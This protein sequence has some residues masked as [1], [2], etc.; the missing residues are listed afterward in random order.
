MTRARALPLAAAAAAGAAT[1]FGFAPF[2]VAFLPVLTLALLFALWQTATPRAAAA[3]GFAFGLALFGTGASWVYI[4]LETFGGTPTAIALL[5]TAVFVVLLAL[6]PALAGY[7]A[8][9]AAPPSSV[10]RALVAAGAWTLAEWLRGHSFTDFPW[11]AVGY[12]Q[13]PGSALAGYAP[14]GGV[15]VVSLAV[16]LVAA[17]V[18]L[19]FDAVA[20]RSRRCVVIAGAAT[21]ALFVGGSLAGRI[22]WT[23]PE[24]KPLAVSLVQGNVPQALKFD[25]QFREKTFAIYAELVE[26]SRGRLIV[27]PE[28][29]YPMFS[30]EVPDAVI[31]HLIRTASA[32]RGDVLLGLFTAEAPA[33][34]TTEPRYFNTV[35]ALGES[36]LQVYRKRHLM[37]FGETIPGKAVF[38]WFI[39]NV[40]AIPL[41]DQT[42]GAAQQPPFAVAGRRVAV[43]ICY[44]DAF[45]SELIDGARAAGF[46]VN[47]TNDAWYGRSIAAYQH[48]QIAAMRALELGRPMLRATNTG[49]T[50]AIAHT[51]RVVAELPWFS[52]G[53]LEVTIDGRT[54]ATP[55]QRFGDGPT[56]ALAAALVALAAWSARRR[57]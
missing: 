43:N 6:W 12:A 2:G 10:A 40:L 37:P 17:M 41:A 22:A 48:N 5:G 15:F 54:G 46:L 23:A 27:L 45:G 7:V 16:A 18:A 4:A 50:S 8:A 31:H 38:G 49:I 53:V 36:D 9:R 57:T 34:G 14:L 21:V 52:R 56:L 51:G 29:A 44:E 47:V 3:Q 28:S 19:A 35:V 24:G 25:P 11:L 33:P 39:R 42:P 1:V 13:L 20:E 30:D 26:S 55:Y 32:R